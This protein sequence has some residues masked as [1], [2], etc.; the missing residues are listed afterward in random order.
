MIRPDIQRRLPHPERTMF[1]ASISSTPP[2]GI[3]SRPFSA[4]MKGSLQQ[5]W[6]HLTEPQSLVDLSLTSH[7]APTA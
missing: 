2:P 3:A 1:R 4:K 5:G 6:I 7:S